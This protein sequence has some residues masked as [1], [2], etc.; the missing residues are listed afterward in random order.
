MKLLRILLLAAPGMLFAAAAAAKTSVSLDLPRDFLERSSFAVVAPAAGSEGG[1]VLNTERR[2]GF[3]HVLSASDHLLLLR[4][5]G[6]AE[7]G[8]WPFVRELAA[9]VRDPVGRRI[10]EWQ[11]LLDKN[12][13]ASFAQ[14]AEFLRDNPDWPSR[15]A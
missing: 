10:I 14:I 3:V 15:E 11:C 7:H 6:A 12:S 13:G 8:N 2:R 1:V 4:A 5:F 9:Q